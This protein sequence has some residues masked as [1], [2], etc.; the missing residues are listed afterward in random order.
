LSSI[1][2]C[3]FLCRLAL[4]DWLGRLNSRDIFM[5]KDFPYKDQIEELCIVMVYRMY[6]STLHCQ[7]SN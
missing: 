5:S 4:F 2:L 1:E 3:I 7:L 6:S